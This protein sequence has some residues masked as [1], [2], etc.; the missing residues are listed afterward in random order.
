V[1]RPA[2]AGFASDFIN[3]GAAQTP[4]NA[5]IPMYAENNDFLG[6]SDALMHTL[7]F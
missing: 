3:Q 6:R 7:I 5:H 1:G 2:C 4:I